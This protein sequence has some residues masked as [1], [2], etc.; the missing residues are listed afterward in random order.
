MIHVE[1]AGERDPL[2][3]REMNISE[4]LFDETYILGEIKYEK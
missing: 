3:N 4:P 2:Y 1:T